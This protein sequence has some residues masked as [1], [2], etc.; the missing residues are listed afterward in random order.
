MEITNKVIPDYKDRVNKLR[1]RMLAEKIDALLVVEA[2]NIFYLSGSNGGYTGARICFV[3]GDKTSTLLIDQ[4]YITEAKENAFADNIISWNKPSYKELVN[5]VKKLG[6][7]R[8]GF[9]SMYT[10]VKQYERMV[11]DFEGFELVGVSGLIEAIREIKDRNEIEKIKKA[12]QIGDLAFTHILK[13]IKSG[14]TEADIGIEIDF[15]MRKHGAERVSFDT[16]VASG[17]NSAVPHATISRKKIEPGDFVTLDFGAV[18]DGYHSDMTRTVVV[19]QASRRQKKIYQTVKQAQ[20]MALDVVKS[21][22]V[23][24]DVDAT[25]RDLIRK[26]GYGN[27]FI[28]NL[29]HGVGLN[30]HEAPTLGPGNEDA[31]K[32]NMVVTVEPGIYI[33]GFGGVRIEDLIVVAKNG[34]KLLTHSTKDLLEL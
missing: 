29:G 25:A 17:R 13:F 12:A 2:H 5:V 18:V 24:K 32:T 26:E 4:R 19:G 23:C 22:A 11:K 10:T 15:F 14:I 27:K 16:I 9:E 31:L 20:A 6:A 8:I 33:A 1:K 3:V 34:Y 7:K 28:H 21:G 30:V